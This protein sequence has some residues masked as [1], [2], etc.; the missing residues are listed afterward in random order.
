MCVTRVNNDYLVRITYLFYIQ[1][2]NRIFKTH[3]LIDASRLIISQN[4]KS[5]VNF[6]S[7]N[8]IHLISN[9]SFKYVTQTFSK[10]FLGK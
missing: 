2:P 9:T 8:L 5:D 7:C 10:L 4:H 6:S 1:K 3:S